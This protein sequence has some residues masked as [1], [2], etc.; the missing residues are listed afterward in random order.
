MVKIRSH[1]ENQNG[2]HEAVLRTD[3]RRL[4]RFKPALGQGVAVEKTRCSENQQ[5]GDRTCQDASWFAPLLESC[6]AVGA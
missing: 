5:M 1:S 6:S 3:R 4:Q 2:D